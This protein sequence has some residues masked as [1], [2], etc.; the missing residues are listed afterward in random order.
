MPKLDFRMEEM[1]MILRKGCIMACLGFAVLV[2]GCTNPPAPAPVTDTRQAD[3]QAVRD[4]EAAMM[5]AKDID[6][7]LTYFADDALGLYPGMPVQQGKQAIK[8]SL[9]AIYADPNYSWTFQSSSMDVSKGGDMVYSQG[10][11]AM[12]T[13]DAKTKKPKT[14]SGKYLTI[15]RKQADGNWKVVADADVPNTAM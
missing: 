1:T 12:T 3:L 15:Y 14:E 9:A 2:A 5:K 4:V 8:T 6:T 13:T 11:Y 7:A 10:T